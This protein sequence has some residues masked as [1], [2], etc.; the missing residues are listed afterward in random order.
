MQDFGYVQGMKRGHI[1]VAKGFPEGPQQAALEKAGV[2][3]FYKNDVDAAIKSVR[4][5]EALYVVGLAGLAASKDGIKAATKALHAKGAWATDAATG[6][7][8]NGVDAVDL[9]M[10]AAVAL[11]RAN[12]GGAKFARE[13]GRKGG[14]AKAKNREGKRTPTDIAKRIWLD[15]SI[16]TN[17]EAL[18]KIN[19][20][21]Y[22][23][24]WTQRSAYNQF[25]NPGRRPGRRSQE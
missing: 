23:H 4:K 3:I 14:H 6:R 19:S 18:E 10:E 2:T 17:A 12:L 25:G 7:K 20:Q 1:R 8:S 5:G 16:S 22:S 21:G 13:F 15:K 11:S 24:D 9:S